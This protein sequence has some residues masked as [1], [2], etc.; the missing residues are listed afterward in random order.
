MKAK[1][2]IQIV[3][4]LAIVA[5]AYFVYSSIL[6]PVRFD[7]EFTKR[8]DACA[9][10]LKTIRTLEDAYKMTYGTYCGNFDTLINRLMT[11]DS[12]R[13]M[14]KVYNYSS[15]PAD[16]DINEIS[17][18]EAIKKGYMNRVETFVNPISQLREL[19]KLRITDAEGEVH[20]NTRRPFR[21]LPERC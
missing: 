10:K 11:E 12:L 19:G 21:S 16:V 13:I 1:P 6:H 3:L 9:M 14:Q 4:A 7:N 5:L 18:L 17:D 20:D 8:R 2:I 15:I